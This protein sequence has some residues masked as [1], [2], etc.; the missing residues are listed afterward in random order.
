MNC[1]ESINLLKRHIREYEKTEKFFVKTTPHIYARLQNN[2]PHAL[3]NS[4][5]LKFESDT[6]YQGFT[7][8][9]RLFEALGIAN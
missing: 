4:R 3:A 6:P 5:K 7:E 8:M 2:L 9:H 1:D